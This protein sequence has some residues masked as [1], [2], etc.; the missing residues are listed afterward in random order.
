MNPRNESQPAPGELRSIVRGILGMLAWLLFVMGL[1]WALSGCGYS[2]AT[3]A[4]APA[5][6]FSE[7]P[8]SQELPPMPPGVWEKPIAISTPQMLVRQAAVAQ[9]PVD[10]N[11]PIIIGL[12]VYAATTTATTN[13]T[14]IVYTDSPDTNQVYFKWGK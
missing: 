12:A 1:V 6:S 10:T 3:V 13:G 2:R 14:N 9:P 7:V 4:A 11:A 5:P 8:K